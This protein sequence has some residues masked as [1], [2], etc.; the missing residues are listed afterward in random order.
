MVKEEY[1]A[2]IE[3]CGQ[4]EKVDV[5]YQGLVH[6]WKKYRFQAYEGLGDIPKLRE[7]ALQFLYK[8]EYSYYAKL[9][10]LYHPSEW[11]EVLQEILETFEKDT[12]LPSAYLEILKVEKLFRKLLEYCNH[13]ISSIQDLYPYLIEDYFEEVNHIFK[14]LIETSAEEASDRKKY[15]VVCKQIKTYKKVCGDIHAHQLIS[16]LK[17]KYIRRP[18]FIDELGKIK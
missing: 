16:D 18:A 7:M 2:V 6:K 3:L 10:T 15:K 17:Q 1:A 11:E 9:K 12:Y 4:G 5:E 8:N 13:H 14:Q